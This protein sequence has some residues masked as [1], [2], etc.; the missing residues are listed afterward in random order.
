MRVLVTGH[1]GYIGSVMVPVLQAAGHEVLGL[2]T[3]F[4]EDCTFGE[5]FHRVP[6][7]RKDVRDVTLADLQGFDAIVHLA[8]LSNDPLGDL[9]PEWTYDINHAASVRLAKLAKEAGVQRFLYAS[10]CSMY[11][12]AGEELVTEET[13]L[14][15]L[16]AYAVSKVRTEE[17]LSKLADE[18]FSPVFMRNATAYGVSPRLRADLV[19][20]NLV[21]WAH[22]TGKVRI[23]S[24]GTPWRPIVHVEDIANAFAAALVAPREAIHNQAFNVGVNGENY[25]IRDLAE[26][27]QETVPGCSVEYAG[28]GEPDQRSYRVDF[29]KLARTLDFKP[30]WNARLG[31][32]ELY[33]AL[34]RIGLSMEDFQDQKYIRLKRLKYLLDAG[35][36]DGTLR[37]TKAGGNQ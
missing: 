4:Y 20:N 19:L 35:Y 18:S 8:A 29:S 27:V 23:L 17:D 15:P 34:R 2:D 33:L 10:S 6:A 22:T 11:G 5:D 24:D 14:S 16:T 32:Q 31:A 1:N 36:L 9:K 30:R 21:C 12:A 26:I 13:P 7:L 37:W 3:F 25:Q 28:Q